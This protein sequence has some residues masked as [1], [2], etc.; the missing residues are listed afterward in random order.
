MYPWAITFPD[1]Q[2]FWK[3]ILHKCMSLYFSCDIYILHSYYHFCFV[4]ILADL[5]KQSSIGAST[6]VFC[7]FIL[8][9]IHCGDC[10]LYEIFTRCYVIIWKRWQCTIVGTVNG[11]C[12]APCSS[13]NRLI[14]SFLPSFSF[15]S[16]G[17]QNTIPQFS[18]FLSISV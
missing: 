15:L 11:E 18:H 4:R 3:V 16:S 12:H 2:K 17:S 1:I 10:C 8:K 5:L 14:H 6:D 13:Y 9:P 7:A